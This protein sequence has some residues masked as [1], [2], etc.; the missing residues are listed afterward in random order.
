MFIDDDAGRIISMKAYIKPET[1]TEKNGTR[2][3]L[4]NIELILIRSIHILSHMMLIQFLKW[5][6]KDLARKKYTKE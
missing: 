4:N 1:I 3:I 6:G 5:C 2:F